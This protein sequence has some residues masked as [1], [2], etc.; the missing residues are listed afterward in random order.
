VE[1][2]WW[3]RTTTVVA[4]SATHQAP[5]PK[6]EIPPPPP[7]RPQPVPQRPA[8]GNW[9]EAAGQRPAAPAPQPRPKKKTPA[10]WLV[11]LLAVVAYLGV[12]ALTY[13]VL[14]AA[15]ADTELSALLGVLAAIGTLIVGFLR[16]GRSG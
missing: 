7:Q 13:S 5:P 9:W 12:G 16:R 1:V 10:V 2:P 6:P 11:L 3:Q 4:G 8:T 15:G 14:D